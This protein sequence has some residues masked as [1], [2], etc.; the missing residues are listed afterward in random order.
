MKQ[1]S[2]FREND[3]CTIPGLSY[4]GDYINHVE[5]S[6]LINMIDQM[7]WMTNLKRRTQHYGYKY[8]YKSKALDSS[9]YLGA[10]PYWLIDLASRLNSDGIFESTPNQVIVNE[11][12]P[13]QGISPHIDCISCF[14]ATVCSLSLSSPCIMEF[15]NKTSKYMQLLERKSLLILKQ[16]ARYEWTHGIASRKYDLYDGYKMPRERRI[17]LTFRTVITSSK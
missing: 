13:G 14:G 5:E 17:S 7:A 15:S 10:L 12:L 2:L 8:D 11:Y 16:C 6:E 1:L 4:I 3:S 9:D